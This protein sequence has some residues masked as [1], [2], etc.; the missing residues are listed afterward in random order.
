MPLYRRFRGPGLTQEPEMRRE[1]YSDIGEGKLLYR[2]YVQLDSLCHPKNLVGWHSLAGGDFF[3][4]LIVGIL[5]V[6]D[7]VIAIRGM[8][9]GRS[10]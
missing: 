8:I 4:S 10:P 7:E 3:D 1:K 2:A 6:M 9:A 5:W